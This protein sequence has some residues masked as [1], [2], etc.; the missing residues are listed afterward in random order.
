MYI[1][2]QLVINNKLVFASVKSTLTGKKYTTT[3]TKC[4]ISPKTGCVLF[5]VPQAAVKLASK[6]AV[7]PAAKPKKKTK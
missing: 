2:V 3:S 1:T 6:S 4:S 7:K 5:T